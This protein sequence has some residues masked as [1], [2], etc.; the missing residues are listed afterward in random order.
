MGRRKAIL[1]NYGSK[2]LEQRRS[3]DT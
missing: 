3:K 1:V 2:V